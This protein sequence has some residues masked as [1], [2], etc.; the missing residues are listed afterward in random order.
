[1][2]KVGVVRNWRVIVIMRDEREGLKKHHEVI[3]PSGIYIASFIQSETR[4]PS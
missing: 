2:G 1:M 4:L 3:Y